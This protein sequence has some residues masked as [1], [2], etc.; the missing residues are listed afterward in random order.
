MEM[1]LRAA[2]RD[3]VNLASRKPFYWGGLKGYQLLEGIAEG[4]HQAEGTS[5]EKARRL[6]AVHVFPMPDGYHNDNEAFVV[7][8]VKNPVRSNPN[9]P[10]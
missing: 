8:L 5:V 2:I 7:N 1:Q 6:R 3:S 10:C 4:L 9:S